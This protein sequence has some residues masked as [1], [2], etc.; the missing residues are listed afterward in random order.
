MSKRRAT[1]AKRL[2]GPVAHSQRNQPA[3]GAVFCRL[4]GHCSLPPPAQQRIALW[5][6]SFAGG[7]TIFLVGLP[8][9]SMLFTPTAYLQVQLARL[10]APRC[11]DDQYPAEAGLRALVQTCSA[12][13]RAG[14]KP[15]AR[16]SHGN[17]NGKGGAPPPPAFAARQD[18]PGAGNPA[19]GARGDTA[20]AVRRPPSPES[21]LFNQAAEDFFLSTITGLGWASVSKSLSRSPACSRRSVS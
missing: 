18:P 1:H 11:R 16:F 2:I 17:T 10:V 7:A 12:S 4:A 6:A 5:S 19:A 9:R 8:A 14:G 13:E 3:G 21:M 15:Q 20:A